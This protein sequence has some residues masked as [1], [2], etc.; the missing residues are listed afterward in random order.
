[1]RKRRVKQPASTDDLGQQMIIQEVAF[2]PGHLS[3]QPVLLMRCE[4]AVRGAAKP[5]VVTLGVPGG[6][7]DRFL[8]GV[9]HGVAAYHEE[10]A[11]KLER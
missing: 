9:Q 4:V 3:G 6:N 1:M 5:Q 8:V 7:V 10:Q 2:G 11:K